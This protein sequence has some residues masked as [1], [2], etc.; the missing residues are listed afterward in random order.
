MGNLSTRAIQTLAACHVRSFLRSRKALHLRS[1]SDRPVARSGGLFVSCALLTNSSSALLL[2]MF[3][4]TRYADFQ[5]LNR[6]ASARMDGGARSI[7]DVQQF[8]DISRSR[9]FI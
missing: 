5:T 3:A 7:G 8:N 6:I 2:R 1:T 9:G 4:E